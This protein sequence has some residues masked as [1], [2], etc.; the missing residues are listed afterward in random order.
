MQRLERLFAIHDRLRRASPGRLSA[1][2]LA[3]EFGVTRRTIERDL[4]S[5]RSAGV[6]LYAER[7]RNGGQV[8]LDRMGN[9]VVSLTPG[10]VTALL[11]AV[12]AAGS[13]MPFA[14]AAD[15][16]V[17][18]LLD[19]LPSST[20]VAVEQLRGRIRSAV[21]AAEPADRR[22]RQT[23]E[24]AVQRG[25]VVNIDYVDGEGAITARAVEAVGLYRG[26]R[27]WHLIGWCRLRQG[28]RIF[29]IDRIRSA[30]LTRQ[31]APARD[32]EETL[33]WV[34]HELESP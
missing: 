32:V 30:R 15:T 16:A 1:A 24:T 9:T 7:G 20:R 14:D 28:G 18:R 31:Q 13:D 10:E 6:P 11:V 26:E 8:S 5:L 2:G 34:P 29:R 19:G 33:G 21:S 12:T 17:A 25:L 23:V 3:N 27:Y 4:A 22:V